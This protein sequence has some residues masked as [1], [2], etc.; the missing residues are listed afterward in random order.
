[1]KITLKNNLSQFFLLI[2][3]DSYIFYNDKGEIIKSG[4]FSINN[5]ARVDELKNLFKELNKFNGLIKVFFI[6]PR[7]IYSVFP[8]EKEDVVSEEFVLKKLEKNFSY[9]IKDTFKISYLNVNNTLYLFGLQK[10]Y[11]NFCKTFSN[12]NCVFLP[13]SPMLLTYSSK[14]SNIFVKLT[15]L[16]DKENFGFLAV[17]DELGYLKDF[18]FCLNNDVSQFAEEMKDCFFTDFI[19]YSI[20][21]LFDFDF[22]EKFENEVALLKSYNKIKYVKRLE[23]I[24]IMILFVF[25][26][27]LNLVHKN[28]EARVNKISEINN[29]NKKLMYLEDENRILKDKINQIL[30]KSIIKKINEILQSKTPDMNFEKVEFFKENKNNFVRCQGIVPDETSFNVFLQKMKDKGYFLKKSEIKKSKKDFY[31]EIEVLLK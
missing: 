24:L 11:F 22:W 25:A 7:V 9:N 1:M 21:N 15:D 2:L 14:Y 20:S 6:E 28:F 4:E 29:I 19:S 5:T 26:I 16:N 31:F 17:Y 12:N 27:T 13:T 23:L 10:E 18:I 30:N 8:L 3:L